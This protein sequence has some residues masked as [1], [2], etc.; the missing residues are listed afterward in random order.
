MWP[1]LYAAIAWLAIAA[2]L[3]A[4]TPVIL[5]SIDTLRADH[6]GA[7]G[8]HRIATLN[9]DSFAQGGTVFTN[10]VC[11]TPLTLPSHTSLFTSTYPFENGIQE[12]AELVPQGAVTLAGVLKSHGYKTAAFIGS[13]FLERQMGLDQGFDTYDSPFNF[14]A[15]SHISGEMYFGGTESP[16]SVRDRRD[17][18][19]VLQAALRWLAANREQP[20]FVF[21]H[22]FDLHTPYVVPEAVARRKGISRYD[23]QLEY[24]DELIGRLKKTLL[25]NGWWDKSLSVLVSDH[26]EGL[27]DHE[28]S[29]HGY[30]IYQSTLH[31]PVIF[32]WPADAPALPATVQNP[33][34]L[35]DIAP[36]ILD[37]LHVPTPPSF[38]GTSLLGAQSAPVYSETLHTHDAFGWAPLRSV[39]LGNYKYIEAPHPELYDLAKDPSERNNIVAANPAQARALRSEIA[40]LLALYPR[41]APATTAGTT[42][43]TEKLLASLGYLAHGPGTRTSDTGPDPKDRLAEYKLYQNAILDLEDRHLAA[44]AAKLQQVLAQDAT[45]TLARRDL[46]VCYLD[47]HNYAKSRASFEQVLKAAPDDY[48]AQFGLGLVDKHLGL[49]DEARTHFEAACRIAPHAAQCRRE[50][51]ALKPGAN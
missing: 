51:D 18:A 38:E 14:E 47:L 48:P 34:G 31:V 41:R 29:S 6:V 44:A 33:A 20:V 5:I 42:P 10:I 30:F 24:E 9:I 13:V 11:Q 21:I 40:K 27:G 4:A 3:R 23:A 46:A 43:Q 1:F 19:L 39:R 8:Y 32:H 28:E 49:L 45:N 37:F 15:F 22:L 50:L 2:G 25:Q 12:N 36:T 16:Y 26:G 17:G 35:I 7:Y